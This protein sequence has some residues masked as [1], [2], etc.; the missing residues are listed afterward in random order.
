MRFV[1]KLPM[2][3][4][5][6]AFTLSILS[7]FD[8]QFLKVDVGFYPSNTALKT[9]D[10]GVGLWTFANIDGYCVDYSIAQEVGS[11]LRKGNQYHS[12]FI[13]HD[14]SWSTARVVAIFSLFAGAIAMGANW[15]EVC[16]PLAKREIKA[17]MVPTIGA[18]I[19]E[20]TK[21]ISFFSIELCISDQIWMA[22]NETTST[23][24]K[25]ELC[26]VGRGATASI[27]AICCY[28]VSLIVECYII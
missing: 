26:Y 13:N 3:L 4:T 7:V 19:F 1:K 21:L 23:F 2:L 17:V 14:D 10:F 18:I 20:M 5:T 11:M 27:F 16:A 28:F 25:A 6:S 15:M 8:C 22:S 24:V 9:K 12:L